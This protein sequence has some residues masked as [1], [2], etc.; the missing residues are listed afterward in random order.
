MRLHY[1]K[2]FLFI[3]PLIIF[4]SC[5]DDPTSV[6]LSQLGDDLINLKKYD[7]QTDSTYQTSTFY[8]STFALGSASRLLLGKADLVESSIL[9]R[10]SYSLADSV[11]T[12]LKNKTSYVSNAWM[13]LYPKYNFPAKA[14][15]TTPFYFRLHSI[16]QD[17]TVS[18]FNADSLAAGKVTYD[19][20]TNYVSGNASATDTTFVFYIDKTAAT[21]WLMS[22]ADTSFY[23]R[24]YGMILTPAAGTQKII[25]FQALNSSSSDEP[26]LTIVLSKTNGY[27]N[28]TLTFTPASDT[29]VVTGDIPS[30]NKQEYIAIQSGLAVESLI[31][32]NLNLPLHAVINYAEL[33]LTADTTKFL[34]GSDTTTTTVYAIYY[35]KDS[36]T[37]ANAEYDPIT[38]T[39]SGKIYSGNIA[40]YVKKW[41]NTS[42]NLGVVIRPSDY[43]DS[44]NKLVFKG[45]NAVNYLE[46]PRLKITYTINK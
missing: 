38:L 20:S 46:R 32:F 43:L 30:L 18:G 10:F 34:Y 42:N 9:F 1:L 31:K 12:Q 25:E 35:S 40:S 41:L 44:V 29:H 6:G 36:A 8:K 26:S 45:S 24:D 22:D 15:L 33:D 28:D 39:K 3:L 2:V 16:N 19:A 4:A 7:T 5:S 21:N 13:E 11:K 14:S 37:W 23:P 27:D 17:W